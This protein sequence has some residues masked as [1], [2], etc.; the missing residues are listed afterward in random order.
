MYLSEMAVIIRF[1]TALQVKR[2]DAVLRVVQAPKC[3]FGAFCMH[4]RC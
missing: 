3:D 4:Q 1:P 2:F